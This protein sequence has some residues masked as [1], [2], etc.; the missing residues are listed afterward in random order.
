MKSR[1]QQTIAKEITASGIGLHS[2]RNVQMKL[3]PAAEDTGI[4]FCRA[5]LPHKPSVRVTPEVVHVSPLC[6]KIMS[7]EVDISTVEHLMAAFY[8][9]GVDNVLVEVT[10]A[11]LP[12]FDGSSAPFLMLIDSVGVKRQTKSKK[13]IKV[14]K[15]I[16]VEDGDK[17]AILKPDDHFSLTLEI[18]FNH[19]VIGYQKCKFDARPSYFREELSRARTFCFQSDVEKMQSMGLALGGGLDNA[20][21]VGDFSVLN[22]EGLRYKDECIRHKALDCIGDLYMV[23]HPILGEFFGRYTGHA[24]NNKLLRAL[25][26]DESNYRYVEIPETSSIYS[27][28]S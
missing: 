8:G 17:I 4:V 22:A 26:S 16:V 24:M 21:V 27:Q 11:E 2:G 28:A 25:M 23:G 1:V 18:D 9:L 12:V 14:M 15:E 3:I 6:T 5:D 10:A 19:P 13:V 7:G 20:V